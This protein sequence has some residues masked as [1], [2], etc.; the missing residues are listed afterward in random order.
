LLDAAHVP[1]WLVVLGAAALAPFFV[2]AFQ[3]ALEARQ[4]RATEA[5]LAGA[6]SGAT[7]SKASGAG[8]RERRKLQE[9]PSHDEIK[10]ASGRERPSTASRG[11]SRGERRNA[12]MTPKDDTEGT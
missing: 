11:E 3:S 7:P 5:F 9:P 8:P 4:K 2:A 12:A 1:L 10:S 6:L